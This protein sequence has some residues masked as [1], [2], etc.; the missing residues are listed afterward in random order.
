M[1][2][3]DILTP[4]ERVILK[5]FV[6]IVIGFCIHLANLL[7]FRNRLAKF[8]DFTRFYRRDRKG[9]FGLKLTLLSIYCGILMVASAQMI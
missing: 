5:Y 1:F 8:A 3:D 4:A 6:F 7:Y 2:L 9:C